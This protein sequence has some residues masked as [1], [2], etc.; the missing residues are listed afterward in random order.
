MS[1]L[2]RGWLIELDMPDPAKAGVTDPWLFGSSET[3]E[4]EIFMTY[5]AAEGLVELMQPEHPEWATARV[6]PCDYI[7][8]RVLNPT[9]PGDVLA[10][11]IKEEESSGVKS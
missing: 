7:L 4:P 11:R 5:A 1:K 8:S 6:V 9:D 2:K 3:R 10:R